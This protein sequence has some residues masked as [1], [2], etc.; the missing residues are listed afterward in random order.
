MQLWVLMT[1]SEAE[2]RKK[3]EAE[4]LAKL[5]EIAEKQRQRE[6]EL[7]EKAERQR[8]E[9]L[10]GRTNDAAVKP[11]E[12]PVRPLDS[13]SVAPAPAPAAA[14]ASA[15]PT[16]GIY[17]PPKFRRERAEG[18]TPVAPPETDRWTGNSSKQD[19]DSWRSETRRPAFGSGGG[20]RSSSS[21]SSSRRD[22]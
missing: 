17:V 3:E 6:L 8:R 15:A 16:P 10:L 4:R 2:R 20:S 13:G 21:W 9:A 19:G 12:P 22:R 5:A 14:A 18:A 1:Y 7:E 11:V